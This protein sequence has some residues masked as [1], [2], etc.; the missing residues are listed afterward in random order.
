MLSHLVAWS[1]RWLHF[2]NDISCHHVS[3]LLISQSRLLIGR[4]LDQFQ[5]AK[6]KD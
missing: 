1:H 5:V 3:A 2:S 4:I 6:Y